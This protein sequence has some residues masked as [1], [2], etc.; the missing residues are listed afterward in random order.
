[1]AEFFATATL[2]DWIGVLGS[3]TICSAYFAVSTGRMNGEDPRFHLINMAGAF[4][5]L[6]SLWFRPNA[7]AILIEVLWVGIALFAL[8]RTGF[9]RR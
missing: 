5:L 7:G 6:Y 1:M 3:F 8:T 9:K 4:M 2:A